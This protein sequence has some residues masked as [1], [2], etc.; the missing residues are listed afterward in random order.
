MRKPSRLLL[1]G[2]AART[3]P[4][5][6]GFFPGA[7]SSAPWKGLFSAGAGPPT[8]ARFPDLATGYGGWLRPLAS[9]TR[10][11]DALW[12]PRPPEENRPEA[13]R[14]LRGGPLDERLSLEAKRWA[15]LENSSSSSSP[16][17]S[18]LAPSAEL[19]VSLTGEAS[20]RTNLGEVLLRPWWGAVDLGVPCA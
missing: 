7:P 10:E 16:H 15:K 3:T 8:R 9:A 1:R 6:R 12:A 20:L 18:P 13:G 5:G 14:K 2:C 4:R 11:W 19:H 17:S